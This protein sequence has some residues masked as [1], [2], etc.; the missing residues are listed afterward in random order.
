[1]YEV[2][3][4]SNGRWGVFDSLGELHAERRSNRLVRST[5]A[6][7]PRADAV[8]KSLNDAP[9]PTREDRINAEIAKWGLV[10]RV[11]TDEAVLRRVAINALME[12]GEY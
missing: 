6:S 4:L 3:E 9:E 8:A 2:K 10:Y 7:K 1:M 11:G 12:R 5:F